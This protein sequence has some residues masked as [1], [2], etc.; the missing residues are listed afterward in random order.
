MSVLVN[1]RGC[2]EREPWK[3]SLICPHRE[4]GEKIWSRKTDGEVDW[5]NCQAQR[6]V[7]TSSTKFTWRPVTSS[8]SILA[9][10]L[11][12]IF[13]NDLAGGAESTLSKF[14][15]DTKLRDLNRLEKGANTNL[16]KFNQ[17]KREYRLEA[18]QLESSF[19]VKALVDKV[20]RSQQCVL[21]A[22]AA[23]SVLGCLRNSITSSL[24]E[25][26]LVRPHLECCV[27]FW[28][29]HYERDMDILAQVQKR[30]T[31]M[32]EGLEHLP[33]EERHI[34]VTK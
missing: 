2:L 12:N 27:Q 23:R 5:L 21:M 20:N 6:A 15:D 33:Y 28:A 25:P 14:A 7:A 29:T 13:I 26:V 30:T 34:E 22:K 11:L 16:M 19:A 9:P 24:R 10:V 1:I 18:D 32:I 4:T 8:E 17:G 3:R 31:K